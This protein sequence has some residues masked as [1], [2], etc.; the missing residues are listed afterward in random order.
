MDYRK[1]NQVT[2]R[3]S[4]PMPRIDDTLDWLEKARWL[5]TLDLTAGY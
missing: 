1:L 2:R 3:D 5:T 4:F